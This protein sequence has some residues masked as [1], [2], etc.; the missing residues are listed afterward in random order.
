MLLIAMVTASRQLKVVRAAIGWN[1]SQQDKQAP[2]QNQ[3][4][5]MLQHKPA[6]V[7]TWLQHSD[8]ESQLDIS[9]DLISHV[10]MLPSAVPTGTNQWSPPLVVVVREYVPSPSTVNYSPEPQSIINRWEL[11]MESPPQPLHPA[12]EQL[13]FKPSQNTQ[14]TGNQAH[15]RLHKLP[16]IIVNKLVISV[17]TLQHGRVVCFFFS[18]GTVQYRDRFT[19]EE[20]FSEP[21]PSRIVSLQHAGFQFTDPTP[22]LAATLSPTNSSFAQ[23]GEDGKVKWNNLKYT[24]P[25]LATG[26]D[27][28]STVQKSV[29]LTVYQ[30]SLTIYS[31]LCRHRFRSHHGGFD[32]IY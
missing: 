21:N 2:L 11:L 29:A 4:N 26:P 27:R 15:T 23:V 19:F 13:G 16:P 20:V 30:V 28:E 9:S 6:A 32:R 31:Q 22:C 10:E 7:T 1:Q 25:D 8:E 5:P 14:Q 24:G 17:Q 3:L 18:D 12:F